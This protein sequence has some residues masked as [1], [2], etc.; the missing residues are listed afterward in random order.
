MN[1]SP[2][3][4]C[5]YTSFDGGETIETLYQKPDRYKF[6]DGQKD[7]GYMISRGAGLSYAAASFSSSSTTTE[8]AEFNR[9][10]FLDVEKKIIE[11]ESGISLKELYDVLLR[12]N[13][14][15]SV[16]PGYPKI[17]IGGC[18][19]ADVHGKN[20]FRDGT[21]ISQVI[22]LKLFHP[23][24]GI[25]EISPEQDRD[26]FRL[27]CGGYGLTGHIVSAKLSLKSIPSNLV[28]VR[29]TPVE[30]IADLASILKI[31]TQRSDLVYTWHN[32]TAKGDVFGKGFVSEA[33][34]VDQN[35]P[36]NNT[37]GNNHLKWE[38]NSINRGNWQF[39]FFNSVTTPA[40]NALYHWSN[41]L[42]KREK[43]ISVYDFLFP[44]YNVSAQAYFKL[45]G[46]PGFFE[47]QAIIPFEAFPDYIDTIKRYLHMHSLAIT[48][49]SA[50]M[51]AGQKELLRYT[52]DGICF[53]L[54]FPRNAESLN[55]MQHLDQ[56]VIEIG[57]TPNIIKDS[58]LPGEIVA[59]TYP[60]YELFRNRLT[61]YD[62]QRVYRSQ[63][64]ER[65]GL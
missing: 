2:V 4:K 38:L 63:L 24:H 61:S 25:F 16:Q 19:A 56:L 8:H 64:S 47:Y 43:I 55:F 32:L 9:I 41:S 49:A 51:F 57:G 46:K 30:K 13:L 59:K 21:F 52:G 27:T 53:A 22:S 17:S 11:V 34:F 18:I 29:T 26:L 15:L 14:F 23:R 40:F 45:F 3:S 35:I 60:E 31:S 5:I 39:P 36:S 1:N 62:P 44:V 54:D 37:R 33:K 42:G 7:S 50:K 65:L 12:Y 20:Q 10:L 6:W 28:S 58:R 48:L